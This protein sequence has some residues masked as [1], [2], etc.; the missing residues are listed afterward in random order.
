MGRRITGVFVFSFDSRGV[1]DVPLW[2][3][4]FFRSTKKASD[5]FALGTDV[6][7]KVLHRNR[8]TKSAGVAMVAGVVFMTP[9][10]IATYPYHIGGHCWVDRLFPGL[11]DAASKAEAA[12]AAG[13]Q[14]NAAAAP[15]LAP[16]SPSNAPV[17]DLAPDQA[18]DRRADQTRVHVVYRGTDPGD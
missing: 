4:M 9:Q 12:R 1:W 2:R 8:N 14:V 5:Y 15:A 11:S 7:A 6:V 13:E 17:A 10:K 16:A 3:F 18:D